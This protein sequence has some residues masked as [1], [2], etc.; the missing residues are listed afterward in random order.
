MLGFQAEVTDTWLV[1]PAQIG[2]AAQCFRE[3][4][5]QGLPPRTPKPQA[6]QRSELASEVYELTGLGLSSA[7][8]GFG[9]SVGVVAAC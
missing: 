4:M 1:Y 9:T 6:A 2:L 7:G 3:S 5:P 8:E